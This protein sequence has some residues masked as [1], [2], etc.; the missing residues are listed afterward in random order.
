MNLES[1]GKRGNMMGHVG[2][3]QKTPQL[4]RSSWGAT[5]PQ[6]VNVSNSIPIHW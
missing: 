2:L 6:P 1:L 4:Y 5:S 3:E